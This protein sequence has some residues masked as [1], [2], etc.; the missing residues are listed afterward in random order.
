[1]TDYLLTNLVISFLAFIVLFSL[2]SAPA[3]ARFYVVVIA[4]FA[5]CIPWHLVSALTILSEPVVA[6][7]LVDTLFWVEDHQVVDEISTSVINGKQTVYTY[8]YSL[9]YLKEKIDFSLF[10]IVALTV[11]IFLLLK[12]IFNYH[13]YLN[14]LLASSTESN[15]LWQE[16]GFDPQKV[17]IRI[18]DDTGPGMATGIF[19]PIVWLNKSYVSDIKVKTILTHELNHIKQHD[20]VW[21]WMLTVIK[22]LNWWNPVV[23]LFTKK[24]KELI[25]LS[26]DEKCANQLKENYAYDLA[27]IVLLQG[28]TQIPVITALNIKLGKKFNIKRIKE[29]TKER[30]MKKK[31]VLA[32]MIA[33]GLSTVA[34]A[35]VGNSKV[36]IANSAEINQDERA[37]VYRKNKYFKQL[38]DGLVQVSWEAKSNDKQTLNK[39]YNDIMEW[40][41][42]R[43]QLKPANDRSMRGNIFTVSC[44]LLDKLDRVDEIPA[45]YLKMF[46]EEPTPKKFY[47]HHLS[48][49]YI[50]SGQPELAI[51]LMGEFAY[52]Q[53]AKYKVGSLSVLALAYLVDGQYEKVIETADEML[54]FAN[55]N[56]S[57]VYTNSFKIEALMEMGEAKKAEQLRAML[58]ETYNEADV[59]KPKLTFYS[60]VFQ[61]IPKAS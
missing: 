16:H 48:K 35:T 8:E 14:R 60:P 11:G 2:K 1:M 30:Q 53:P 50:K 41:L 40:D 17:S 23:W 36:E 42:N 51:E 31:H 27:E 39:V 55:N 29:L 15:S 13:F 10:M 7:E 26:C 12:D 49:A 45:L 4:M 37:N 56:K 5:W 61:Y 33:A 25:E 46:P 34:A 58:A 38:F 32:L 24:A 21:I 18:L 47:R 44:Y 52:K 43:E 54:K 59:K 20:P 9:S 22:Q 6:D 57:I 19:K 3:R 28:G